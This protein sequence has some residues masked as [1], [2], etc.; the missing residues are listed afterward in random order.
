M[1]WKRPAGF[2]TRSKDRKAIEGLVSLRDFVAQMSSWLPAKAVL[3]YLVMHRALMASW[4]GEGELTLP[5]S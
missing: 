5:Q 4:H 2:E 1:G 3:K